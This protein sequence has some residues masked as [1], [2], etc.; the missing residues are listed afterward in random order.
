MNRSIV[1]ANF[2]IILE[3]NESEETLIFTSGVVAFYHDWNRDGMTGTPFRDESYRV[4]RLNDVTFTLVPL[5]TTNLPVI[6]V[7]EGVVAIA[8]FKRRGKV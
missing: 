1:D 7:I 5:E 8:Y 4:N 3:M 2:N 6:L